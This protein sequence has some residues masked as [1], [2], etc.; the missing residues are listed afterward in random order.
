MIITMIAAK[1][2]A[3]FLRILK[4]GATTLP[5]RIALIMK[6]NI[7]TELSKGVKI[8]CV[9]GTNGKTTTCAL[10]EHA[11]KESG[12]QYLIN[13]SGAN[14]L[15]GVATAFIMN[16][17]IT[18]K[19]RKKAAILECDENSFPLISRYIDA[20]ITVVTNVF[21]DQLDRYG[22]VD[23]TLAKIRESIENMPE[24]TLVLNADDPL[25]YSLKSSFKN[26]CITFGVSAKLDSPAVFDNR[27]CPLCKAELEYKSHTISQ[28][29][30]FFC[31]SCS[32]R[33]R[34]PDYEISDITKTGFLLNGELFSTSLGG[35]YNYYN[36]C[37]AAAV[38]ETVKVGK[39]QSLC[40]FSGAFGRMEKFDLKNGCALLLLVKNPAGLTGCIKY[41]CGIEG[42]LNAAF[43][44]NDKDADGRDVSWVWDSDFS[45][46]K[47]KCKTV[48]TAGT[49]SLDMA[50]RLKYDGIEADEIIDGE[51]Y[52]RLI[53]LIKNSNGDFIIFSTYTAMMKMRHLFIDAFGGREFWK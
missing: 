45:P 36:I 31:P 23:S 29:G 44:L 22:E 40:T 34:K 17:T 35:L 39:I 43:A 14:M 16:S 24:T 27:Y 33:R 9:T 46:L 52:R 50:L 53:E 10:L 26:K 49:R 5:G 28:L 11:F 48:I 15:S 25:T 1:L 41:V 21:R 42:E 8:I 20:D 2:C 30:D 13:K 4:K 51:N 38:I 3:V 7:L 6:Y 12:I 18:G 32:F 19:C 47:S 37:A